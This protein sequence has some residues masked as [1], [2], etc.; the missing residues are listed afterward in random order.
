M[1]TTKI[2]YQAALAEVEKI[3]AQLENNELDVDNMAEAVKRA[4]ELLN[5][6]RQKLGE[7]EAEVEKAMAE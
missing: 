4:A 5:L 3:V 7:A 6:C 2:S 1:S